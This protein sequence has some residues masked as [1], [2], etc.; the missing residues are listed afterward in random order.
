MAFVLLLLSL[1]FIVTQKGNLVSINLKDSDFDGA[2]YWEKD[3]LNL[4]NGKYER[5][6]TEKALFCHTFI[7]NYHFVDVEVLSEDPLLAIFRNF[8]PSHYVDDFLEDV[9]KAN[10]EQL[11][12]GTYAEDKTYEGTTFRRA[13]GSWIDHTASYGV[14]RMFNRAVTLLP[15]INFVNSEPWQVIKY[16]SGGHYAPHHDYFPYSSPETYD[17]W[18]MKNYGNRM[19]TFL[20]VLKTARKGGGT[21][22]PMLHKVVHP[23]SGDVIFWTNVNYT[24]EMVF[25]TVLKYCAGGHYAPHHDYIY[26]RDPRRT[27]FPELHKAAHPS[28]G[29][30]VF[31][32]NVNYTG[33]KERRSSHGGC[34]VY[35]GEKIVA[36]LW[37]RMKGQHIFQSASN[38]LDIPLFCYSHVINYQWLNVEV[39]SE[40]PILIIYRDFA[41]E[42]FVADFLAD[43]RQRHLQSQRVLDLNKME[44]RIAN[45]TWMAHE[46]TVA[47]AK[48]FR[49]AR[50][51][52]P[53]ID[54]QDCEKW[55]VLSYFPGGH[56]APHYD[57]LDYKSSKQWDPWYELTGYRFATF[58][59]MLQPATRGGG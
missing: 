37:I 39:L 17:D 46:E 47:V 7:R 56:Y 32:I 30:V 44:A 11:G 10:L 24:G 22:F 21:V 31:W 52:L 50:M 13:N 20:L 42:N 55:Q 57:Y 51:M 54:F 1:Y 33:E 43:A 36:T 49:R 29:D 2:H 5:D 58:F 23:S 18:W 14:A 15:F 59:L 12:V 9:R 25:P 26:I 3:W 34:P 28:R 4:C 27:V 41:P 35:K 38:R 6:T 16:R 8:A 45:G 48:M 40:D 19:A 53:V